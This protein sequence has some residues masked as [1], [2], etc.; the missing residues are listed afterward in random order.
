MHFIFHLFVSL[1]FP[2][3]F[4]PIFSLTRISNRTNSAPTLKPRQQWRTEGA[5]HAFQN[6]HPVDLDTWAA[7]QD[8]ST[9]DT[10]TGVSYSHT[11][12]ASTGTTST[13]VKCSHIS[14]TSTG[15][16]VSYKYS[17][18]ILNRH[19]IIRRILMI[20]G[21]ACPPKEHTKKITNK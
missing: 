12:A 1:P 7:L 8:T 2:P 20:R 5:T 16:L 13:G 3:L 19:V 4:Y 21:F 15:S 14:A 10:S 9:A 17:C 18:Q 11:A 6:A